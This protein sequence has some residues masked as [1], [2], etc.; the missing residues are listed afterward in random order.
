MPL[1]QERG[2][3]TYADYLSWPQHERWEIIDGVAYMQAAPSSVHQEILT[4]LLVQFHQYLAGKAGKVYPAPFCVRLIENDEK[5]DE[6][7]IK[8]VEPDITVVCDKSKVDEKGCCGVPDL[9]VEI[10]SPTSTEM[11][12]LVK[13]NKYEKAGV[14]EYW[15]VEPEGRFV[16]VFVLRE[17]K[18]GRPEIYAE[19][20]K[21]KA[22]IFPDLLIDLKPVFEGI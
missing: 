5:N 11:D 13:F 12:K 7:I 19:N 18:Y 15:I 8:V 9:I 21:I 2:N 22:A 17:Q 20:D 3:F 10:I 6:E 1:P 4:G 14:G 16:S